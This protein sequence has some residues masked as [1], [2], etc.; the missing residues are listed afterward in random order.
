[1]DMSDNS[2]SVEGGKKII[3]LC[4]KI[5]REDIKVTG[6]LKAWIIEK[7]LIYEHP[8]LLTIISENPTERFISSLSILESIFKHCRASQN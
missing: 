5:T 2:S 4:E 6:K 8:F 1:M 7:S 3:L